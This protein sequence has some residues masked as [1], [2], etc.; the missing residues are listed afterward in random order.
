M[1]A[2]VIKKWDS[3]AFTGV[4]VIILSY[5]LYRWWYLPMSRPKPAAAGKPAQ[6]DNAK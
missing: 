2:F 6:H 4:L 5:I 1:T 3:V